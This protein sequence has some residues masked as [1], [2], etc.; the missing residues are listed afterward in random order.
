[1]TRHIKLKVKNKMIYLDYAASTPMSEL[2]LQVYNESVKTHFGNASSLHDE[3]T[4]A[5]EAL[6]LCR[7]QHSLFINGEA[8]GFYFTS[9]GSEAN[10]L[11][12]LS[13]LKGQA[14]KGNHI[15]TT[16]VVHASLYNLCKQ[17][18]DDG[19]EVTYLGTN[20]NGTVDVQALE[21]AI[22]PTTVLASIHH[23]NGEIGAVQPLKEIGEILA[24]HDVIFHTDCVQTY[25]ELAIDVKAC[26]IDSLSVSSHKIYGPKGSGFCY[27]APEV[28]WKEVLDGTTHEHGFRTGTV[29]VPSVMAF[30]AAA[31]EMMQGREARMAKYEE[32]RNLFLD[33]MA[34]L[35]DLVTVEQSLESQLPQIVGLSF[36]QVQGQYIM[37]ECNRQGICISTGSACQV[38]MQGPSRS[39]LA[40]GKTPAEATQFVRLSFGQATGKSDIEKTIK[41]IK[42]IVEA[43]G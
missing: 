33:G 24:R 28:A 7:K 27:I 4:K 19:F 1:M 42:D 8:E 15:I 26:Q 41:V 6:Q 9:G 23:A 21:A 25:G 34:S 35:R 43:V 22:R 32:L 11:A 12:I 10:V 18:E 20:E 40:I 39:M 38:G 3:G 5:A 31:Q 14:H 16:E 37:L 13:I 30:T 17:L 36:S 2:A 29:D